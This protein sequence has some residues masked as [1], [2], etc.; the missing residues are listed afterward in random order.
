MAGLRPVRTVSGLSPT[1]GDARWDSF[2]IVMSVRDALARSPACQPLVRVLD[3]RSADAHIRNPF[4]W[5][6]LCESYDILQRST[7]RG[8]GHP[9]SSPS[10]TACPLSPV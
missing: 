7:T 4:Y 1:L 5:L 10:A 6:T 8:C 3:N 9:R 2:F